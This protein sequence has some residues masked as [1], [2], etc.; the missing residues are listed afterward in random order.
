[1]IAHGT[2]LDNTNDFVGDESMSQH[3]DKLRTYLFDV[4]RE[5]LARGAIHQRR[6][7]EPAA[8][9]LKN[10]IPHVMAEVTEDVAEVLREVG[11]ELASAGAKVL[12][13]LVAGGVEGFGKS[14]GEMI[15]GAFSKRKR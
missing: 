1:M 7:G 9:V 4:T 5:L 12:G 6:T 13:G 2:V 3:R 11:G 8:V 10:H 15:G 14:I